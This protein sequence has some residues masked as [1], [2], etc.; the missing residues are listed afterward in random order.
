MGYDQ[1]Y[2]Y[3]KQ[4]EILKGVNWDLCNVI[5]LVCGQC[6]KFGAAFCFFHVLWI[7]SITFQKSNYRGSQAKLHILS[8]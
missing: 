5:F 1:N 8:F 3:L 6:L 4:A 2:N 7:G